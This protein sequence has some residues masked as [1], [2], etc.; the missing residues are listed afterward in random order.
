[1]VAFDPMGRIKKYNDVLEIIKDF[2]YVRLEYYQKRKDYMTDNLQNQLLMLS[3]Q[4]RFIK[5][6]I[7]KQLSVANKKRNNWLH[8]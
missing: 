7:E 5:M 6:I 3:E 4:A 1:M 8:C 2:Y